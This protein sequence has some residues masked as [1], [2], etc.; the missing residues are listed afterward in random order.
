MLQTSSVWAA[1][2]RSAEVLPKTSF[3]FVKEHAATLQ[4]SHVSGSWYACMRVHVQHLCSACT[5]HMCSTDLRMRRCC[6]FVPEQ[7][8]L[9]EC[10]LCRKRLSSSSSSRS[11]L[12]REFFRL[13]AALLVTQLW[14][15]PWPRPRVHD[16]LFPPVIHGLRDCHIQTMKNKQK[17]H[18]SPTHTC[19]D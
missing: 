9:V 7:P 5:T 10:H 11:L 2:M 17:T 4:T 19:N 18:A 14:P 3:T 13:S 1:G 15:V 6:G 12:W 8:T 16:K